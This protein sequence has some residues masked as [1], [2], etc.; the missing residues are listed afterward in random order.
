MVNLGGDVLNV[1]LQE[2]SGNLGR[3]AD[4]LEHSFER[5]PTGAI[6]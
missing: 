6:W 3:P 5:A 2:Q 4:T 1:L